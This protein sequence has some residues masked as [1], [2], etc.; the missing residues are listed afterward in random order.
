MPPREKRWNEIDKPVRAD[1][2]KS[3]FSRKGWILDL[4]PSKNNLGKVKSISS[5]GQLWIK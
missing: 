5:L 3:V 1:A 4:V 2:Y